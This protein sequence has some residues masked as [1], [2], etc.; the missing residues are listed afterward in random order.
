MSTKI[1]ITV[2]VGLRSDGSKIS[3]IEAISMRKRA[4]QVLLE[5]CGA[6]TVS[7]GKGGW[8][9]DASHDWR[10]SVF[11]FTVTVESW[12]LVNPSLL[13]AA[14]RDIFQQKCVALETKPVNF[15]LV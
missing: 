8:W 12:R 5:R 2:G 1:T 7:Y 9:H 10:E 15:E 11:V 14:I 4:E 3:Q 13:A 6:Y